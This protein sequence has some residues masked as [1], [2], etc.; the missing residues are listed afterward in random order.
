VVSAD[1]INR[2][3]LVVTVVVGT[4]AKYIRQDYSTNVRVAARETGLRKDTVFLCFQIRSLDP[5]RF[6]DA[7]TG[8][9]APAGSLTPNRMKE[10][11]QALKAA[12]ELS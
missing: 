6:V 9:P 4:D 5:D 1:A 3:P 2:R 7:R 11:D 12:L 8:R 10:V